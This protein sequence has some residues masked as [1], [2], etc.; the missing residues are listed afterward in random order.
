MRGSAKRSAKLSAKRSVKRSARRSPLPPKLA[1]R[2]ALVFRFALS[3]PPTVRQMT[4]WMA[5]RRPVMGGPVGQRSRRLACA[6]LGQLAFFLEQDN[7]AD[8]RGTL[9][10]RMEEYAWLQSSGAASI[11]VSPAR[12]AMTLVVPVP[13]SLVLPRD[14]LESACESIAFAAPDTWQEGEDGVMGDDGPALDLVSIDA[15]KEEFV[16]S[17]RYRR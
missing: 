13:P 2:D 5:N 7:Y 14:V 16:P 1:Q 9:Y 4:D 17:G 3:P 8:P 6:M 15:T 10:R 11:Q 12:D